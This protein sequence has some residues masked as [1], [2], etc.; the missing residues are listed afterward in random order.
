MAVAKGGSLLEVCD[1]ATGD[2]KRPV[3]SDEIPALADMLRGVFTDG[4]VISVTTTPTNVRSSS[5]STGIHGDALL[6]AFSTGPVP[7]RLHERLSVLLEAAR[8]VTFAIYRSDGGSEIFDPGFADAQEAR[9]WAERA[10]AALASKQ[11]LLDEDELAM[12]YPRA[13][14]EM[15]AC[16]HASGDLGTAIL[17]HR[18]TAEE[19]AEFWA[20]LSG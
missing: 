6:Q 2:A 1:A 20:S 19:V 13:F 10:L 12:I 3:R 16:F 14:P 9:A 4:Q 15:A 5:S 17:I 7:V 18:E 11:P 8:D